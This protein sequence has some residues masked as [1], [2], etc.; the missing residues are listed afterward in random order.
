VDWYQ[1][2]SP[3]FYSASILSDAVSVVRAPC[4]SIG[5]VR[6]AGAAS[7]SS[8]AAATGA[9]TR[10]G[11]GPSTTT[12]SAT[13]TSTALTGVTTTVAA[14]SVKTGAAHSV[15]VNCMMGFVLGLLVLI[16]YKR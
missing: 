12:A 13:P 11:A 5:D 3:A 1:T 6:N 2:A 10:P 8:A 4:S 7:S 15:N 14:S 16:L 9:V